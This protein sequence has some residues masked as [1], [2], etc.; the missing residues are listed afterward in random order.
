MKNL[1]IPR[2]FPKNLRDLRLTIDLSQ[3]KLGK[4]V[5]YGQNHV[6]YWERGKTFPGIETLLMLSEVFSVSLDC[7][8]FYPED[9]IQPTNRCRPIC[10]DYKHKKM[11]EGR[12]EAEELVEWRRLRYKIWDLM[13]VRDKEKRKLYLQLLHSSI[14]NTHKL[15]TKEILNVRPFCKWLIR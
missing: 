15:A 7:L 9:G 4:M 10:I 12:L 3:E 6:C 1:C 14:D 13:A 11:V 8:L 2:N 5:G